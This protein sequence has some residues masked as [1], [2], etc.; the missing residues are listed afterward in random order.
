MGRRAAPRRPGQATIADVAARAGV[1]ISTVSRVLNSSSYVD[2]LKAERIVATIREL[3]FAPRA[4][5]RALA[6]AR[7]GILGL[8]VPEI[9]DD[10]FLPML[11]GIEGAARLAGFEL[12]IRT[13]GLGAGRRAERDAGAV[14]GLLLFADSARPDLIEDLVRRGAPLVLLYAATPAGLELP[15][16]TV[17]NEGGARAAV[18]HLALVHGRRRIACLAGPA[19]NHDAQARLRGYRAALGELGLPFDPGLVAS[20]DFSSIRAEEATRALIARGVAFDAVFACDDGAALGVL[21]ALA[22]AGRR[23][24]AEVSVVGFDDL[25]LAGAYSLATVRAPTEEVGAEGA[26]L[27]IGLV[28][29][30]QGA[31]GAASRIFPT[32]FVP[33]ASCGCGGTARRQE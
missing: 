30:R 22:E 27:L 20:G 6:G 7:T 13:T 28:E 26:R 32:S 15:S 31:R 19:G 29:G 14:D 25:S 4:A 9:S 12:M 10:F 21:S 3:G 33:R 16:L 18:S 17:D 2:P 24:G 23:P 11:R 8:L 5:A 1:S